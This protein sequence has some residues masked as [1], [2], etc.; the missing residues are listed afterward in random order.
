[1]S[2]PLKLVTPPAAVQATA[3]N[4][5]EK[6]LQERVREYMKTHHYSYR[7]EE[8]YWAWIKRYILFHG[9]RHP[10]EMG[11]PEIKRY[12]THLALVQKVS[13]RTQNQAFNALLFLYKS[14]L[15]INVGELK[16]IPR[17]KG[18]LHLP[19]VLTK[20]ETLKL[21]SAM[22]GLPRL[23]CSVLYGA[24]LRV[25][26]GLRLRIKDLDFERGIRTRCGIPLPLTCSKPAPTSGPFRNC[27]AIS[28]SKQQ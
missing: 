12:L 28:T 19:T 23:I 7:T 27:S 15:K 20:Q 26:E 11:A 18:P 3:S 24:G 14:I 5:P 13:A 16:D 10:K 17:A 21:L 22:E 8:T 4:P 25:M 6:K 1:M 2:I 9:K